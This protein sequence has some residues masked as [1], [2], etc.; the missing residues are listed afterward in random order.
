MKKP[1]LLVFSLAV[2]FL[3]TSLINCA[4]ASTEPTQQLLKTKA[5]SS[6]CH[7][8]E[9]TSSKQDASQADCCGACKAE[10]SFTLTSSDT[11][12]GLQKNTLSLSSL[13]KIALSGV[14]TLGR[15]ADLNNRILLSSWDALRVSALNTSICILIQSLRF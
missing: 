7:H 3:M 4:C 11:F 13:A 8:S 5:A 15:T 14:N 6:D 9:S 12:K 2:L 1:K 10:S